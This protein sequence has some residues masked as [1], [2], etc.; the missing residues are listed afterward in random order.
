ML[1][2]KNKMLKRKFVLEDGQFR[3]V[4]WENQLT[5]QVVKQAGQDECVIYF[6]D[7]S[8]LGTAEMKASIEKQTNGLVITFV[9]D[10]A[11]LVVTYR[12][13]E[14]VLVKQVVLRASER[15]INY[16]DVERW[17]FTDEEDIYQ[18]PKQAD[19]KEMAGFSGYYVELG[20]PVY[21]KGNFMGM[22]FPLGE[23]R[24]LDKTY[25][26]RYY[27]GQEVQFP[28][29]IW[30]T[31][32]GASADKSKVGIQ[33]EF[34]AYIE[35]IAQP[36]YF[37]KQYNSWYDHMKDIDEEIILESFDRIHEGFSAYGIDLDA[38]VVDDGWP[39]YESVWEFNEKFPN[40][41]ASVKELT[42]RLGTGLGLWI[43]PRGGYGETPKI[44][45]DWLEA[46]P[47]LGI[48][49]KNHTCDDVNVA[50][51]NYLDKMQ[52][53]MLEYQRAYDISY[54]KIDGWLLEPDSKDESGSHA[55]HTMTPVYE[56]LVE[57]L[58][59]LRDER[60]EQ[61]CWLNLT[62]YVN[63]SP[64]FLQWVNSLWIQVSQD[65]GFDEGSG[66]DLA[67]MIT[68]RDAQY[69]EFLHERAIQLPL[70]SLYN[71]EPIYAKTAHRGYLDH[72]MEATPDELKR[73]LFFNG[74]RGQS[75]W[76][77]HYSYSMFNEAFWQANAEAVKWI[78]AH[79]ETLKYSIPI[80]GN[81]AQYEIYGYSCQHPESG[82]HILSVRNPSE[83]EQSIELSNIDLNQFK[84]VVG[85]WELLVDHTIQLPAH[86]L[87]VL[88]KG[89]VEDSF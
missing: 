78:D 55:M 74:T 82:E 52:E 16:I 73:Y 54:W 1:E 42:N 59:V 50:D 15:A 51:F 64:W 88:M 26:S 89:S 70:W 46:H 61:D 3:T 43:G 57:L 5:E 49:S 25:V 34:F 36:S 12:A 39:D 4:A 71:H 30:P 20:Q 19:I 58:T 27:V 83:Y 29:E 63:P 7:G 22:E 24:L 44:M 40:E 72:E 37:R 28:K 47:E 6:I 17:V 85:E 38:Y 31:V 69:Y 8:I 10:W 76:E 75:L 86:G 66:S 41:L 56:R 77:F 9:H 81:P 87:I 65:T 35:G 33:K 80:G 79:Y 53:K 13:R 68:Y 14:D 21:A 2:I 67:R 45:S 48:G 11:E 18:L 62:S 23:N 84:P 32:I 60:G